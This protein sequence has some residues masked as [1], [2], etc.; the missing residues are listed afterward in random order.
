MRANDD[1]GSW[2]K[3]AVVGLLALAVLV[4]ILINYL[5]KIQQNER[6]RR[7]LD[8]QQTELAQQQE[9]SRQLH[10][11][12]DA[13]SHDPQTVARLARE[14]LGYAKPDE[15]VIRFEA[16]DTNAVR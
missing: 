11:Q 1:G 6:L 3:Q 8:R 7:E 10:A 14:K 9:T 4:L 12:I 13:L 2:L 15:T 5:P 16:P